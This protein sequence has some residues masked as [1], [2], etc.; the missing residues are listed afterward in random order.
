M[1]WILASA[2]ILTFV[3]SVPATAKSGTADE[4]EIHNKQL[5]LKI[6]APDPQNGFYK[7]VRFDW[8]GVIADLEFAGHHL[9]R[10]WFTSVDASVPDFIYSDSGIVAGT[11][12]AMTGPVEEFQKPVGYEDAAAGGTFLKVGVGLLRKIDDSPYHFTR[13]FPLVDGGKWSV[14][15]SSKSVTFEQVLGGPNAD[16]G[17]VYTKTI[18]LVGDS[19]TFVIEHHLKNTG[20]LPII[21]TVYDHN[22]LTIDGTDVG[23]AYSISV[24]YD[25]QPKPAPNPNFVS[26]DG[27]KA[28]YIADLQGKDRA[29]FGL[30]GFSTDTKDYDFTIANRTASVAV[31]IKGDRPLV[32]AEVWSI[33]TVL[34][35]EP[36]IDIHVAPGEDY[37][38]SYTYTYSTL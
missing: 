1:K 22:F 24:P 29:A 3:A 2:L 25:I 13:Q 23:K 27:K 19:P 6:Y 37:D 17:Y 12:S 35:V 34:A 30:Q 15:K 28:S 9:Y 16:Y 14:H 33:R 11:N 7:G 26:I 21:T 36:F 32:N 20:K 8:S 38:W 31:R 10:P 4:M 5:H 18:R